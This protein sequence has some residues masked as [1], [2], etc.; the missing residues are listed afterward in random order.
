MNLGR[1]V[2]MAGPVGAFGM[3]F[4]VPDNVRRGRSAPG[5]QAVIA[6]CKVGS[7][8]L[9]S[10]VRRYEAVVWRGRHGMPCRLPRE[11][12]PERRSGADHLL[13]CASFTVGRGGRW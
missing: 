10:R 13:H 9:N 6:A 8:S 11:C 7:E 3:R 12:P 4:E 2:M 1:K 5:H